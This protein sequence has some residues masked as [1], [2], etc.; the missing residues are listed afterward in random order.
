MKNADECNK[1]GIG[2][3]MLQEGVPGR[4]EA[5]NQLNQSISRACEMM[6]GTRLIISAMFE[7]RAGNQDDERARSFLIGWSY[8]LLEME[9][10]LRGAWEQYAAHTNAQLNLAN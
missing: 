2:R 8:E 4:E 1:S 9:Q 3:T 6:V 10:H 7:G 5:E